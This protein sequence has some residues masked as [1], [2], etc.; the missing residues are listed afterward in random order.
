MTIIAIDGVSATGKGTLAQKLAQHFNYAFLDTGAL[1]RTVGYR[2]HQMG[3]DIHNETQAVHMVQTLP[4]KDITVLQTSSSIRT[5]E[6]GGYASVVASM[7][8][9]RKALLDVQRQFALNPVD[10]KGNPLK[11]AVLDGRDIGTVICPDADFKFFLTADTKI[12]AER[13]LK[14]LQLRGKDVILQTVLEEMRERDK[15][16]SQRAVAPVIPAE[17]AYILDT[18]SLTPEEVFAKA[19]AFIEQEQKSPQ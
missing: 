17:D 12:R 14:E 5:E 18:T 10:E 13:R 4:F 1:Y 9:V 7:P 8:Q 3:L 11:G 16:D 2:M 19:L 6:V 15:R